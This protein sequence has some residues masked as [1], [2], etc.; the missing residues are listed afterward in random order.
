M[1]SNV[2]MILAHPNIEK[3]I[4]N[5][6]ISNI[7]NELHHTEIRNLNKLYPDFNIDVK[8]EQEALLKADVLIFQYPLFWYGVPSL[9]KEWIDSVFTYGF[10]FGKGNYKLEGKKIIVSFTTGSSN[11]DYPE[12]VIEKIVFPFKGLASYCKMEYLN[13]FISHEIGGYS[14][15]SIQKSTTNADIHAKKILEII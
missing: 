4:A 11:K 1:A 7:I 15:D 9:L 12:D 2:L 8:S 10:A 13:T 3:S 5:K 14:E 6:Y